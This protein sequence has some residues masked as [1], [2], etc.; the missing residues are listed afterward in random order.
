MDGPFIVE[1]SRHL[2]PDLSNAPKVEDYIHPRVIIWDPIQQHQCFKSGIACPHYDHG[3]VGSILTP[4]KWKDGRSERDMP[5]QMYGVNGPVLLVSHVYRCTRGHEI[6]GHDPRLLENIPSGDVTFH[7]G[8]KLS[9]T[10]ELCSLVFALASS[11]QTFNEIE[12]FLAQRYLDNFSE[13]QCR[14][15]RHIASFLAR[16]T[17]VDKESLPTF[18]S[19]DVW[20]PT[21]S[22]DT[23]LQCFLYVF[24]E[25]E[26]FFRQHMSEK[27][28]NVWI[29]AD[30]TFKVAANIGCNLPDGS[31]ANQFDSLFIVLN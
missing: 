18:P 28:A 21:P 27:G 6:T 24:K 3:Q 17:S 20:R 2:N 30:H 9:L 16:N 26:L 5:R 14:Y 25:N 19:F 1:P 10:S 13:G 8:H 12:V 11:G 7:L 23:I 22:T 15:A 31:W 29:S 4:C